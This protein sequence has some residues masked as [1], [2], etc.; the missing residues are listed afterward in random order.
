MLRRRLPPHVRARSTF[1]LSSILLLLAVL[2]GLF[3]LA[4]PANAQAKLPTVA[5]A[6]ASE[7]P[8]DPAEE[9]VAPDSPRASMAR[10][11]AATNDAR[12]TEA[13]TYL[14]LPKGE[15]ARGPE[16]A[17]MLS[18]VLG[19]R[20]W[21]DPETLSPQSSGKKDDGLPNGVDELGKLRA[22][23]GRVD[24]VR[25]VRREAKT[26]DEDA[27]WVFS[28][29]T[30][31]HVD[32]WYDAL[33]E[34]WVRAHL[35]AF[36]LREGPRT[37]L[38]W[39]L[40]AIGV[41][42]FVG[43]LGGRPFAWGVRK[44]VG[45][46]AVRLRLTWDADAE[47]HMRG[48][49]RLACAVPVFFVGSRF[50]GLYQPADA[51][52]IQLLR[53]LL[54]VAGFWFALRVVASLG[55]SVLA[56]D[57]GKDRPSLRSFSSFT[58]RVGR[59]VVWVLGTV[60]VANQLGFPV[61]SVITG[62]GIGGIAIALAAQKTVENLFGSVSILVDQPFRVGDTIRVDGVEGAVETVG[63]RSTRL[64]TADRSLVVLPNGK[65]ADMRI[66]SMSARDRTRFSTK[67]RVGNG[68]APEQLAGLVALLGQELGAHLKVRREDVLVRLSAITDGAFE[69]DV[70]CAVE[71]TR[72]AEFADVRQELLFTCI[73]T[74]RKV[75][76]ELVQRDPGAS[77]TPPT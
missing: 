15:Q 10:F 51:F 8:A 58:L 40:V 25:I 45:R 9:E 16:L 38:Y 44:L 33:G 29:Q 23:D 32:T 1:G 5:A 21:I 39:H 48:P 26:A 49:T 62:L 60:T 61:G 12:W 27:R 35:P 53:A 56:S 18:V 55:G 37:F 43:Y 3:A 69:I 36:L 75:G 71:T 59:F 7:K 66:E 65:L 42:G 6:N 11:V 4:R 22:S 17:K 64:R 13:A 24:P 46:A 19:R 30:V 73:A 47:R 74:T 77:Q 14:E 2:V 54:L 72:F 76:V 34:R 41:L 63:L 50:L 67:L 70:A 28:S 57:W 68:A 31:S 52:V 20:L